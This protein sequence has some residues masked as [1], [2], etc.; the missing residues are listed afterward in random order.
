MPTATLTFDLDEEQDAFYAALHGLKA[1][2]TLWTID[3]RCRAILKHGSPSPETAALA[4]DVRQTIREQ[5][6]EAL[7]T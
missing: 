3:Q 7:E 4:E 2:R 5:C 6:P 1:F